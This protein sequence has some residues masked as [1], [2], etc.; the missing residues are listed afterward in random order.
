MMPN[1]YCASTALRAEGIPVV[2]VGLESKARTT[3][4]EPARSAVTTKRKVVTY[5]KQV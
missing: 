5:R 4:L 1:L 3:V 2:T